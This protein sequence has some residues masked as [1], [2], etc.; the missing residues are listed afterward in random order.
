MYFANQF[1]CYLEHPSLA[2]LL[3]AQLLGIA[4]VRHAA[5]K[6]VFITKAC[7]QTRGCMLSMHLYKVHQGDF[8]QQPVY[9]SRLSWCRVKAY[10]QRSA[11]YDQILK[12]NEQMYAI[13]AITTSLCPAS[14]RNLDEAVANMLKEK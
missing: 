7:P 8:A 1:T 4:L 11:Q 13:L 12:K 3:R 6:H 14:S 9:Q 2:M 5:V 10:H